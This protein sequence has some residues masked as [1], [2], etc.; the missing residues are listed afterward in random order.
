MLIKSSERTTGRGAATYA[1]IFIEG[2]FFK[3]SDF[4]N[5]HYMGRQDGWENYEVDV[6]GNPIWAKFYRSNSGKETV[7]VFAGSEQIEEFYSFAAAI[8]WAAA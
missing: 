1:A 3:V 4:E 8:D 7:T 2:T 6:P 5:A